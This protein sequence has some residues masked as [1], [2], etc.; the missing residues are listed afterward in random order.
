MTDSD[1]KTRIGTAFEANGEALLAYVRYTLRGLA[2]DLDTYDRA[3]DI[4]GE[5][6]L[7][8]C[9]KALYSPQSVPDDDTRVLAWLKRIALFKCLNET[10]KQ[11]RF[12]HLRSTYAAITAESSLLDAMDEHPGTTERFLRDMIEDLPE[13]KRQVLKGY[14]YEGLPSTVLAEK[15]GKTPE[16]VRKIKERLIKDLRK[17]WLKWSDR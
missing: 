11:R 1:P 12:R 14:F 17:G 5:V 10:R 4:L 8:A 13:E 7:T 16:A 2:S 3:N 15:L 9:E 6:A